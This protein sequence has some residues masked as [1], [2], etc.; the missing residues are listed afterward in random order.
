MNTILTII[1]TFNGAR[2]IE[3]CLRS[4]SESTLDSDILIIDNNSTDNTVD[5]IRSNSVDVQLIQSSTNL[6][7]GGANNIGLLQA[8]KQGYDY[9][10][11]LNQ[12]A[13]VAKDC[14]E[15]LYKSSLN[16]PTFGII[17]PI[18]LQPDGQNMDVVFENQVKKHYH[19][20]TEVLLENQT[21]KNIQDLHEVRFVGAASWFV[22]RELIKKVGLFNP[23]FHHYG[24]D[25]N[26]AARAQYFGFKIGVQ[27]TTSIIHDRK[28]RKKSDFLPVRL[29][30]FPLHQL[31]DIR[32][33][34]VIAW[35]VGYHQLGRTSKKLRQLHGNSYNTDIEALEKWFFED[36]KKARSIRKGLKKPYL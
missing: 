31:L 24:E 32:K 12:D 11:L 6:G 3:T 19:P 35:L 9:V 5:I 14:L 18:Q 17:S 16:S 20:T 8:I 22:T 26:F 33:P 4:L 25:N 36:L 21:Q 29:R 2:W 13:Y 7:F 28:P 27:V 30:T 23:F 1:V 34:F 10:F 15:K